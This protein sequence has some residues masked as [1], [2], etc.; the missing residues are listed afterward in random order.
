MPRHEG[1]FTPMDKVY[2]ALD[3]FDGTR[4][5]TPPSLPAGTR[6]TTSSADQKTL[7]GRVVVDDE[8]RMAR[9]A[10]EMKRE[11]QHLS[12]LFPVESRGTFE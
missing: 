11:A 8:Q 4:P 3:H 10:A 2:D 6:E 9:G 7:V 1:D 12:S 5:P